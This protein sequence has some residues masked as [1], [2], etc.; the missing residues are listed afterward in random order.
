MDCLIKHF[1]Q[2]I[3]SLSITHHYHTISAMFSVLVNVP[4]EEL[5][6]K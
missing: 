2:V 1:G 3:P 5:T 4:V 6:I